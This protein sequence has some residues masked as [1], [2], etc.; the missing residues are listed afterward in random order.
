MGFL[1]TTSDGRCE[2]T[3]RR[4]KTLI[5]VTLLAMF[6]GIASAAG[7]GGSGSGGGGAGSAAGGGAGAGPGAGT[8]SQTQDQIH[9]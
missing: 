3:M 1:V 8:A 4:L 7:G 6:S 9:K 5:V 2:M